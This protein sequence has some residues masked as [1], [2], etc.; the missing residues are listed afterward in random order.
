M[1]DGAKGGVSSVSL[2]LSTRAVGVQELQG[3]EGK[4]AKSPPPNP[5]GLRGAQALRPG[6]QPST[7]GRAQKASIG[8]REFLGS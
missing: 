5:E 7:H 6:E 3:E 2:W 4:V 1:R 8:V